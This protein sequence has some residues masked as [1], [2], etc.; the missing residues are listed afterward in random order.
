MPPTTKQYTAAGQ[1]ENTEKKPGKKT[2]PTIKSI[3]QDSRHTS[4]KQGSCRASYSNRS[5][6]EEIWNK[7]IYNNAGNKVSLLSSSPFSSLYV[8]FTLFCS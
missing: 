2:K 6:E 8:S 7:Q 3:A 1:K 4:Q 5:K